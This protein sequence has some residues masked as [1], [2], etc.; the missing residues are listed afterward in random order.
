MSGSFSSKSLSLRTD[1][2]GKRFLCVSGSHKIKINRYTEWPWRAGVIRCSSHLDASD[3]E[4]QFLVEFDDQPWE[5]REWINVYTDNYHIFL[6]ESQLS[7]GSR[8]SATR[9]SLHPALAFIPL[10]D[11]IGFYK[12]KHSRPLE[13][14]VDSLLDFQDTSKLKTIRDWDP[15]ITG[16]ETSSANERAVRAW[17]ELQGGQHLL[18]NTPSVLIG[19][20]IKVYRAEGTTQ[21]YTAVTTG[22]NDETGEFTLIDD[23]V[24]EEHYEDPRL[25]HLKLLG[26]GVVESIL[27]GENIGITPRRS[28]SSVG[29]IRVCH[30]Y[31]THLP[32]RRIVSKKPYKTNRAHLKKSTTTTTTNTTTNPMRGRRKRSHSSSTTVSST[33]NNNNSLKNVHERKKNPSLKKSK[34]KSN[35]NNNNNNNQEKKLQKTTKRLVV[36]KPRGGNSVNNS[37]NNNNK[38]ET[39]LASLVDKNACGGSRLADNKPQKRKAVAIVRPQPQQS[40]SASNSQASNKNKVHNT[41]SLTN[42]KSDNNNPSSKKVDELKARFSLYD[43]HSDE[44]ETEDSNNS[45]S[46]TTKRPLKF[47]KGKQNKSQIVVIII[48]LLLILSRRKTKDIEIAVVSSSSPVIHSEIKKQIDAST[49]LLSFENR[50]PLPPG[51]HILEEGSKLE[52]IKSEKQD[53]IILSSK[54]SSSSPRVDEGLS[55]VK[56]DDDRSDSGISSTIRSDCTRSSGDERSGSR[57]SALSGDE[58]R[59]SSRPSSH[60]LSGVEEKD[61]QSKL[62]TNSVSIMGDHSSS[63]RSS[64]SGGDRRLLPP[65]NPLS[66]AAAANITALTAHYQAAALQQAG[67]AAHGAALSPHLLAQ[68]HQSLAAAGI[69]PEIL[70]KQPYPQ[71]NAAA[72]AAAAGGVPPHLLGRNDYSILAR[73]REIAADRE[74]IFRERAEAEQRGRERLEKERKEKERHE[75]ERRDRE[76]RERRERRNAEQNFM[77]KQQAVEA[78][79]QHFQLS[80]ELAKKLPSYTNRYMI[81]SQKMA[82]A[83]QHWSQLP[84]VTKDDRRKFEDSR[85]DAAA[86]FRQQQQYINAMAANIGNPRVSDPKVYS[87]FNK[88]DVGPKEHSVVFKPYE[89]TATRFHP[90]NSVSPVGG[91]STPSPLMSAVSPPATP[92]FPSNGPQSH[93]P[94]S[95]LPPPRTSS[96]SPPRIPPPPAHGAQTRP[97]NYFDELPLDLGSATKRQSD[98]NDMP[99]KKA[100]RFDAGTLYKVLEPSVLPPEPVPSVINTVINKAVVSCQVPTTTTTIS[101]NNSS[102]GC[103]NDTGSQNLVAT[104]A[105]SSNSSI[106]TVL[107]SGPS[108]SSTQSAQDT[109]SDDDFGYVHKL[110]KAWIKAYSEP[111]TAPPTP[112]HPPIKSSFSNPPTP[113]PRMTPSPAL[114]TNSSKGGGSVSKS[115]NGYSSPKKES[116]IPLKGATEDEKEGVILHHH[117]VFCHKYSS[118]KRIHFLKPSIAQLKKT[119]ESFL[120]DA[121]CFEVAPKLA[122]CRECRWTQSQRNKKM[123]NIFCRFYAF[124]RLKFTKNGQ[125]AVSG[126]CNPIR[127]ATENDIAVWSVSGS[128]SVID[129]EQAV[130]VLQHLKVDFTTIM[131]QERAAQKAHMASDDTVAWKRVV[132]GVREMCDVCD[133]TLFNFHW[134]CSKCGFVVC[135]DCYLNRKN[136]I[137][138][139]WGENDKEQDKY[140]W[141]LCTNRQGHELDKLVLTQIV[142]GEALT[143]LESLL[144]NSSVTKNGGM[145]PIRKDAHSQDTEDLDEKENK[146]SKLEFFQR[147]GMP[148]INNSLHHHWKNIKAFQNETMGTNSKTHNWLCEGKVLC[149]EN[150]VDNSSLEMFKGVW[151]SGIPIVIRNLT[152]VSAISSW[153]PE[154]LIESFGDIKVELAEALTNKPKGVYPIKK[155][156]MGFIDPEKG[157]KDDSGK[158]LYLKTK[159]WPPQGEEFSEA[160]PS[161]SAEFLNSLPLSAYTSRSSSLNMALSLPDVFVRPDLGPRA[162]FIHGTPSSPNLGTVNLHLDIAD[163]LNVIVYSSKT[164]TIEEEENDLFSELESVPNSEVAAVWHVFHPQDADKIRDLLNKE[165]GDKDLDFDYLHEETKYLDAKLRAKLKSEYG[166][167]SSTIF[168]SPGEAILIPAG[169]PKQVKHLKCCI[170]I[171]SDFV[172]A[173]SLPHSF[174]MVQSMRY[175]PESQAMGED[176]LQ[177]K[178]LIFHS[179]KDALKALSEEKS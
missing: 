108:I 49:P 91:H 93:T 132:Q 98:C 136:D 44:S 134:A 59:T 133:A 28:R 176:K 11:N 147:R 121:S 29:S 69:P 58:Q 65:S 162:W 16:L 151:G 74:R 112:S 20:R 117:R 7:L 92:F 40:T 153:D 128:K 51:N 54:T 5:S 25:T 24:L 41:E 67:L 1:N 137:V 52:V 10:V 127:D 138:R 149:L 166:V 139:T 146:P 172:S 23:T 72:A 159:D 125:L 156:L 102:G 80:M 160:F 46:T 164:N 179:V 68:Y 43:F 17:S 13:F 64:S 171:S 114:S 62:T 131:D 47:N 158:N 161:R 83:G 170:S 88:G 118:I 99:P 30:N 105:S 21:W 119:G 174:Y 167:S 111:N 71:F 163:S 89:T 150:D 63:E 57:S 106:S 109:N 143:R 97:L 113:N 169:A 66:A 100:G 14:L 76:E 168:Q 34:L 155:F 103:F 157:I 79:D 50:A 116:L 22:Y 135:V 85:H 126:F 86:A 95:V 84:G 19:F 104:A 165:A 90:S 175:L 37:N 35:S 32:R 73:E 75:R 9:G 129:K 110:K 2:V 6:V 144:N 56:M 122:K 8:P 12:S 120:Q 115:L 130:K 177:V 154:K 53:D 107:N 81:A 94:V 87:P 3:N 148:Q 39:T 31:G 4:L 42:N 96:S 140:S 145:F 101:S 82:D 152:K 33:N 61:I 77:K 142:A 36:V 78:V 123:P 60:D 70:L 26:E 178:N 45:T 48:T 27:K 124:R 173:E 141:L 18:I 15:T 38:Q 55:V